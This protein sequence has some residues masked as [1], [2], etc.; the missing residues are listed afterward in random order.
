MER[1][2]D[3]NKLSISY[4][5]TQTAN[6]NQNDASAKFDYVAYNRKMSDILYFRL[7]SSKIHTLS[8]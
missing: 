3:F 4:N 2:Y 7:T 6:V 5:T 8:H 1:Y